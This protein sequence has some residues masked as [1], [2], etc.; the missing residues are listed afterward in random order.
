MVPA[1]P[2]VAGAV[3]VD[4]AAD[5]RIDDVDSEQRFAG[6]AAVNDWRFVL[7]GLWRGL[8]APHSLALC[9][10][11]LRSLRR[12][13]R[14]AVSLGRA[15]AGRVGGCTPNESLQGLFAINVSM[16]VKFIVWGSAVPYLCR[17]GWTAQSLTTRRMPGSFGVLLPAVALGANSRARVWTVF[18]VAGT[19]EAFS[20]PAIGQAYP[21]EVAGRAL[22]ACNLIVTG[23]VFRIQSRIEPAI[24][25]FQS[26]GRAIQVSFRG[27]FAILAGACSL[28]GAWFVGFDDS[29]RPSR[30]H[31]AT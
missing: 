29:I 16:L 5:C 13:D 23:G 19:L 26:W 9:A 8:Q 10:D 6:P 14:F 24:D 18:Y 2:G 31:P 28:T 20:Q 17:R 12:L 27:A 4:G 21:P 25:L 22:T 3:R 1:A 7:V 15:L 30:V 11:G